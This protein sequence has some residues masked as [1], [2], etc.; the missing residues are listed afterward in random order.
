MNIPQNI[1]DRII[2]DCIILEKYRIG[3][4]N[5]HNSIKNFKWNKKIYSINDIYSMDENGNYLD[6]LCDE[7]FNMYYVHDDDNY[8]VY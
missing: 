1:Q 4:K 7:Y 3:W 5:I 6:D 2:V 8:N